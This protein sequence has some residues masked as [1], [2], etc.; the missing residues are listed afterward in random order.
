MSINY[1]NPK[2]QRVQSNMSTMSFFRRGG[3]FALYGCLFDFGC[4]VLF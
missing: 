3:C 2:K 1:K 4:A